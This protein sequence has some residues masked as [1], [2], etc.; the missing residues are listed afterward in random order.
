MKI[1]SII[2]GSGQGSSMIFASRLISALIE[3]GMSNTT[4]GLDTGAARYWSGLTKLR[5]LLKELQPDIVTAHYGSLTGLTASLLGGSRAVV[6]F[7]GSDLNPWKGPRLHV[8]M[9]HVLSHMA[10]YKAKHVVCVS[11]ELRRKLW[12]RR[13]GIDILPTGV[14]ENLFRPTEFALA[15]RLLGWSCSERVV[16]FNGSNRLVKRLDRAMKSVSVAEI[17]LGMPIRLEVLEGETPPDRIPLMMSA[18]N[19]LLMASDY[20]GSPTVVQEA[21]ACQ[22]PVVSVDVGDVREMLAGVTPSWIVR[23]DPDDIGRA[24]AECLCHDGS[25]RSNGREVIQRCSLS[26]IAERFEAIY[27]AVAGEVRL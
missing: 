18:A 15:R 3:L 9:S 13:A 14:D 21:M 11:K 4:Y 2:P 20:E 22:L 25:R 16:L 19:C 17:L 8:W 23:S 27:S 1:L 6:I 10:A 7:R 24:L 5:R 12:W 26:G